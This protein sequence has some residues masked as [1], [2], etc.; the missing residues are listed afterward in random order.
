MAHVL[1]IVEKRQTR[2]KK[3]KIFENEEW[4]GMC[5][6]EEKMVQI[7]L[8]NS[9]RQKQLKPLTPLDEIEEMKVYR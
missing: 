6:E 1:F 7:A 9:L 8:K 3:A 5:E 4:V 2:R